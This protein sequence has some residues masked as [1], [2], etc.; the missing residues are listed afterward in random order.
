MHDAFK[1]KQETPLSEVKIILALGK[2]LSQSISKVTSISK[3]YNHFV[4]LNLE[5][6][7][8]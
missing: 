5:M 7:I 8:L 6:N 1:Q 3:C 2:K 4:V